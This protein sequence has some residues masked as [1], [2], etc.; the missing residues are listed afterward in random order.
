MLI[1]QLM[2]ANGLKKL[3]D[4]ILSVKGYSQA[5]LQIGAQRKCLRA[6][7]CALDGIESPAKAVL[8]Q[9]I[10]LNILEQQ[11]NEQ[12]Y[13]ANLQVLAKAKIAATEE[14][15]NKILA[16]HNSRR[17]EGQYT[18]TWSVPA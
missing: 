15:F 11:Q 7:L 14:W 6:A 2:Y 13:Q 18:R 17:N 4:A 9:H 16:D 8:R 5:L 1:Y 12:R 10:Q 3:L